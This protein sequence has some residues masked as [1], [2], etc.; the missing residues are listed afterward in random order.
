MNK[1]EFEKEIFENPKKTRY[2]LVYFTLNTLYLIV[3]NG[4]W[5]C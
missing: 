2:D 4:Y 3:S 5:Y 1:N